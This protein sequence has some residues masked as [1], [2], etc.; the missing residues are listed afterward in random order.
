M[1]A[2]VLLAAVLVLVSARFPD[3]QGVACSKQEDECFPCDAQNP[4]QLYQCGC[5]SGTC[6]CALN[7]QTNR[8]QCDQF[9]YV[10]GVRTKWTCKLPATG[11]TANEASCET[12][13]QCNSE[14]FGTGWCRHDV[15]GVSI[16]SRKQSVCGAVS[17]IGE[18]CDAK[19]GAGEC[20]G[21]TQYTYSACIDGKCWGGAEGDP[22][23]IGDEFN[24]ETDTR[25][26]GRG[27]GNYPVNFR[28]SSLAGTRLQ[29]C[30]RGTFCNATRVGYSA[31]PGYCTKVRGDPKTAGKTC[32]H[33]LPDSSQCGYQQICT[34]AN[35]LNTSYYDANGNKLFGTA[36]PYLE[37]DAAYRLRVGLPANSTLINPSVG[38]CLNISGLNQS[39]VCGTSAGTASLCATTENGDLSCLGGIC[40]FVSN[41]SSC[42]SSAD[43][44][45]F[46]DCGCTS[47]TSNGGV[48]SGLTNVPSCLKELYALRDCA[49]NQ[50]NVNGCITMD[51]AGT[52]PWLYTTRMMDPASR[53]CYS[54]CRTAFRT[55]ACCRGQKALCI[56]EDLDVPGLVTGLIAFV[57]G[58]AISVVILLEIPQ[59]YL[60]PIW[61]SICFWH[62]WRQDIIDFIDDRPLLFPKAGGVA[63][64]FKNAFAPKKGQGKAQCCAG[65]NPPPPPPAATY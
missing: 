65:C 42:A 4:T 56:V 57:I 11:T 48:C 2:V 34:N 50:T 45:Y 18:T 29:G 5:S 53:S 21:S 63:D 3:S 24:L 44:G 26:V 33:T 7:T 64:G 52:P 38:V 32:I 9:P 49:L 37:D 39:A 41:S 40:R 28:I 16:T 25:I 8:S 6:E 58:V 12:D 13:Q 10:A 27:C 60:G 51:I 14:K 61:L 17:F 54:P 43:C 59:N 55:F 62:M 19:G 23:C 46:G 31:E 47:T 15:S 20:R 1:R 36:S 22:C 35:F 30:G